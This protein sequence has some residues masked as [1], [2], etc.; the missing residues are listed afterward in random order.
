[1]PSYI[2]FEYNETFFKNKL[3]NILFNYDLF[4]NK[5]DDNLLYNYDKIYNNFI[6]LIN[7]DFISISGSTILQV[8]KEKKFENSDLDIYIE[9]DKLINPDNSINCDNCFNV[10]DLIIFLFDNFYLKTELSKNILIDYLNKF[11]KLIEYFD[12]TTYNDDNYIS[13]RR[14]LK[15]LLP[16]RSDNKK[17]EL[18][19]ISKSIKTILNNTFDYDIVKN[20]WK[21]N[22]IYCKNINA[23][24]TN[25]ATMTLKHF[26]HRVLANPKEFINFI[27]RYDKYSSRGFKIY[28]HNTLLDYKKFIY[29]INIYKSKTYNFIQGN[30]IRL[31][32]DKQIYNSVYIKVY[33]IT[34]YG[35]SE[36]TI[37]KKDH[38]VKYILFS[39]I[40][41]NYKLRKNIIKLSNYLLDKYLNPE[42]IFIKYLSNEWMNIN[43]QNKKIAYIT[44][45]NKLKLL[46]Y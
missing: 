27:K 10:E 38:I 7:K 37:E 44:N 3:Y 4:N 45:K 8:I 35:Y 34:K 9:I 36:I 12:D 14:Y 41:K 16:F 22:N 13:L 11:T 30:P 32:L 39:G 18:I 28:I 20:Y 1:M 26:I 25:F 19:F 43:K 6:Q 17:I 24:D 40:L 29:I 5:N 46:T 33:N 21:Q 31:E 2:K 23:I 15:L 42:S